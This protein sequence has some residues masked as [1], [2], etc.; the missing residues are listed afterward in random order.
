M[1]IQEA[2]AIRT[3]ILVAV[4]LAVDRTTTALVVSMAIATVPI[5]QADL[6]PVCPP[7]PLSC[8]EE[9]NDGKAVS[10]MDANLC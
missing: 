5:R 7:N 1:N 6:L 2:S 3:A 10:W 8:F 4:P 9:C